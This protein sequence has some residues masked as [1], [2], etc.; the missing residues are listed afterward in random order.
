MRRK[1]IITIIE[2]LMTKIESTYKISNG[3]IEQINYKL[4]SWTDKPKLKVKEIQNIK[5]KNEKYNMK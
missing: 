2:K 1:V 4:E 3:L 5:M